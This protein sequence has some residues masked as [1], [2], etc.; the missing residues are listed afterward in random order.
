M[1]KREAAISAL[2]DLLR[3]TGAEVWRGTDLAREMVPEGLIEV[4]EGDST[5]TPLL[6]PLAWEI[7][8][9]AEVVVSVAAADEYARDA[10]MDALLQRIAGLIAVDRTLG[11]VVDWAEP[12]A[13]TFQPAEIDGAAK[14]ARFSVALSYV[15]TD[16][17]L[18]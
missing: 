5:D 10:A 16:T 6:S 1:S 4:S 15:S 7:E 17:V 12:G 18:S 14:S 8:Q 13:P 2:A 3:Q 11:G 9:H